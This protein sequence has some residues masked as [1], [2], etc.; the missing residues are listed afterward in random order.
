MKTNLKENLMSVGNKKRKTRDCEIRVIYGDT[1]AMGIVY[2][3]N[4]IVWFEKGRTEWL[5]QVGY[6]Y[7]KMEEQGVWLPVSKVE[8][9]YKTPARYDD[10]LI[11]KTGIQKLKGATVVMEYTIVNADT[12]E[13]CVTGT[14]THPITDPNLKPLRVKRDYP[15]LYNMI[16]EEM[17]D[18]E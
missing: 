7:K 5:R 6:P 11:I 4:Y 16:K 3:A 17:D 8:A 10:R 15:E 2:H 9:E 14:T 18:G 12:G 1:D 13:V